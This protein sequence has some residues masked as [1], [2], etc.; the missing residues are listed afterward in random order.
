M[1]APGLTSPIRP[2]GFEN[3]QLNAGIFLKNFPVSHFLTADSLKAA[4]N[5]EITAGTKILGMTTGGGTFTLRRET[6][7]PEVDGRRYRF[8][9]AEFVDSMDA[10]MTSTLVETTYENFVAVLGNAGRPSGVTGDV[11]HIHTAIGPEH[12]QENIVWIG[13]TADGDLVAIEMQNGLNTADMTF[14]FQD[15]NEGKLPFE[16]HAHQDNVRAYDTAPVSVSF[17]EGAGSGVGYF[18]SLTCKKGVAGVPHNMQ[19]SVLTYGHYMVSFYSPDLTDYAANHS[20]SV[21]ILLNGDAIDFDIDNSNAV[22]GDNFVAYFNVAAPNGIPSTFLF[23]CSGATN[24]VIYA[25][26]VTFTKISDII[27]VDVG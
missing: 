2:E 18:S 16:F 19:E 22:G 4:V 13:D 6:R 5:A 14:T 9:G 3:L 20:G 26:N 17:F 11:V 21:E 8:K 15:K 24:P 10:S 7:T 27:P 1:G 23:K 25:Y 12:Y